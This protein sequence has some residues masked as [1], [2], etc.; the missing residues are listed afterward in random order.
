[1]AIKERLCS[2]LYAKGRV[3]EMVETKTER[4][5]KRERRKSEQLLN[6]G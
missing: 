1:M 6:V 5:E 2:G 3:E 4:T